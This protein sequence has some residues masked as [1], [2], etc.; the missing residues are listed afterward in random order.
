[1]G[2]GVRPVSLLG[3]FNR[4]EGTPNYLLDNRLWE[5]WGTPTAGLE[6]EDRWVHVAG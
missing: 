3:R 5:G 1:M 6:A 4:G 2:V